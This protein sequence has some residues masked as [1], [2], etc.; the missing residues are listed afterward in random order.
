MTTTPD[1]S[2]LTCHVRQVMLPP[3]S[4]PSARFAPLIGLAAD[5]G[6]P[7]AGYYVLHALGASDW[8]A[9]LGGALLAGLRLL[10]VF[11]RD[12][13]VTWF[14]AVMLA[15]FGIGLALVFV[16]GD[17]RFVLVKD[18]FVT[19]GVG[20]VFLASLFAARP[21]TFAALE[22]WQPAKAAELGAMWD[23]AP[24]VRRVFRVSAIVWGVGLLT[25]AALRI[26]LIYALPID[27]AVGVSTGMLVTAFVA[28]GVWNGIYASR[29]ERRLSAA[30]GT[31][32]E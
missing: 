19:G 28:L 3:V 11:V 27:V 17:P 13:R 25:E 12:R 32:A 22:S 15:V 5:V 10:W 9:L 14:G 31:A 26:P 21:L 18:S 6:L 23:H 20:L 24:G 30:D 7:V 4:A 29:A 16:S 8:T 2:T 1:M